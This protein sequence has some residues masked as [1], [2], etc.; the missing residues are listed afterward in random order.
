MRT[1]QENKILKSYCDL[2]HFLLCKGAIDSL[3]GLAHLS[4]LINLCFKDLF[5]ND[6]LARQIFKHKTKL[7]IGATITENKVIKE[8]LHKDLDVK[9]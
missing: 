7:K 6:F 4:S 1:E 2:N 5:K 9:L 3:E 8:L